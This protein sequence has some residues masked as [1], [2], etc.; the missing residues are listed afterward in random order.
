MT[1]VER[2]T[3]R[4]RRTLAQLAAS[5]LVVLVVLVAGTLAVDAAQTTGLASRNEA[6]TLGHWFGTDWLGRDVLARVL[7][8]L[9]LSLV[10]GT[11]AAVLSALIALVLASAATVGGPRVDAVVGWLVDLFLA[12]PH[13]VLLI[14]LAF[15]LGGGTEAVIVAVAVTHWP[16]LTRVLR[17]RAKEVVAADFVS[18][19]AHLGR[20]RWWIARRH[21]TGH[22]AGQFLVGLVLLFP[23]AILHEAALSF[24]GL[25]VD[26]AE[27]SIGVLLA[28]SMR[29]LSAGAWWLAVLPGLCLLV[30]VKAV[31]GI[32]ENLRAL[33]NP[34]SHHL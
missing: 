9:R 19:S 3:D 25:G 7:A 13:L 12:L 11:S 8:G 33:L 24:L 32:G 4:R 10:V 30:V 5:V 22:L 26:P 16:T 14:L 1:T 31:D 27:P 15:A 28:E 23:H 21:V 20:G 6:P 17:G 18:V 34:R 29:Y 2:G